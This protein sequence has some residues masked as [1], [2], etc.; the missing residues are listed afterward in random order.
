[1]LISVL[2]YLKVSSINYPMKIAV[3]EEENTLTYSELE[4]RSQSV[5]TAL[6]KYDC[7]KQPVALYMEK[8]ILAVCSFLG[9]VSA[10]GFYCMLNTELPQNRLTQIQNILQPKL[11]ITTTELK[12]KAEQIFAGCI[13]CT[14]EELQDTSIDNIALS[15]VRNRMIDTD[16]LYINF[17]SGSTGVPKGIVVSHRSVIDFILKFL[18]LISINRI[19]N[20]RIILRKSI[21]K[22]IK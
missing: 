13:I 15:Q 3:R 5:G 10:G 8:G 12:E 7:Y 4:K 22:P 9:I 11:I 18:G 6:I 21:Q 1:M 17:T 19:K 14:S 16:P 2:D 20:F